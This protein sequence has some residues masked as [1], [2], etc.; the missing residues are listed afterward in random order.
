ME[1]SKQKDLL[2]PK[3]IPTSPKISSSRANSLSR[4]FQSLIRRLEKTK[5]ADSSFNSSITSKH[6]FETQDNTDLQSKRFSIGYQS[7]SQI[8]STPVTPVNSI[9]QNLVS[10]QSNLFLN[11]TPGISST[12]NTTLLDLQSA[13]KDLPPNNKH[14]SERPPITEKSSHYIAQPFFNPA[15]DEKLIIVGGINLP[16]NNFSSFVSIPEE[17]QEHEPLVSE[18]PLSSSPDHSTNN[19]APIFK[20]PLINTKPQTEVPIPDLKIDSQDET[21]K[22]TK[23]FSS[24]STE[25]KTQE[26]PQTA[27]SSTQQDYVSSSTAISKKVVSEIPE[28]RYTHTETKFE[29]TSANLA[30][31]DSTITAAHINTSNIKTENKSKSTLK[32]DVKTDNLR[33]ENELH[34]PPASV[35]S[36]NHGSV[37]YSTHEF[38]LN[39]YGKTTKVIGKGTGGT[40]RLLQSVAVN[41]RPP[42]TRNAANTSQAN[43]EH[44]YVPGKEKLFAV[45]EFRK[46]RADETPR[47][48]MKKVTS[49]YCIGSSL[50]HENVIETLDLIFEGER[51]FEIMEYCPYD[52]F[53]FVALG[54]MDLEETFCWFKQVCQGVNYIHSL[55]ISHRDLKLENILLT[56][57]GI[58]K[59]IDFGCAT[60]FKAPFQKNPNK[61]T[62]VYGSDPYIAP[63][64]FNK[65]V[66]YDA[67]AADVWSVGIMYICMTLLKFPWR[68]ADSLL[69]TNYASYTKNWPR[70]RDKLFAQLPLLR[71]DGRKWIE[72]LV[73]PNPEVRPILSDLLKSDWASGIEMCRPGRRAKGHIHQMNIE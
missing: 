71:D 6:P 31:A 40:V 53:K 3:T 28:I 35:V 39:K 15:A 43:S 1:N 41:Q 29:F 7:V 63:E 46:R 56:E 38:S 64:V 36:S 70:G 25:I 19:V 30:S 33:A 24:L 20:T 37:V 52:L 45:K 49:E 62:G 9:P 57:T 65:S 8:T 4:R 68:V 54:E 5:P 11:S 48:Y 13:Q 16:R 60:V 47:V 59:L 61:L 10:S 44:V 58:V 14:A 42:S 27:F 18:T 21:V 23:D 51:V 2:G 22:I 55:G 12:N 73:D 34:S 32:I 26:T 50:H 69:D 67:Q 66:P 17:E 72:R